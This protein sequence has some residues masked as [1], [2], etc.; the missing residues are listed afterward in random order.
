MVRS[1]KVLGLWCL[2]GVAGLSSV[3][4]VTWVLVGLGAKAFAATV[5]VLGLACVPPVSLAVADN[6]IPRTGGDAPYDPD[7]SPTPDLGAWFYL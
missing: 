5:L 6:R 4:L 2:L 3:A 1:L 7:P